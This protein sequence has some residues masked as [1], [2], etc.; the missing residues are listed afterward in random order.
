MCR[1]RWIV[2]FCGHNGLVLAVVAPGQGAQ[3]SGFLSAWLADPH[4]AEGLDHLGEAAGL[5]L[6]FF[7][8]QADDD[9]IRDTAIA[10]P[11]LVAAG[12][13]VADA[14]LPGESLSEVVGV[15]AGHS[16]GEV[17]AAVLADVLPADQAMVFIRER[18]QGMAAAAA[19]R[20]TSMAA[21][22]GGD[23]DEVVQAIT[24][25]DLTPANY[26]GKG[27]IVAAGTVEQ[28]DELPSRLPERT[29]V[30][31][32]SVAGAFHTHHMASG[33][34]RLRDVV[35]ALHPAD[36]AVAILSNRDGQQV[37]SGQEYVTRLVDQVVN[38]VRWDLCM[39]T[40]T[41][42]G[43]TGMLE[44]TPAGTLTGIAKRNMKVE[45]FNLNT[46]DQLGEA[47]Q[48]VAHHAGGQGA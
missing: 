8:T 21:V 5:D 20:P 27:Q 29:R 6:R 7:G 26:N 3:K 42:M 24:S 36:P 19:E 38:P 14:L 33:Q 4:F 13:L 45:L 15:T 28:L 30:I 46:P 44:L 32:L 16:V 31:P 47:R 43:V 34:A 40:M 39:Q 48:F 10:Q 22:I 1:L 41:E 9:T 2:G 17:T 12:I 37:A 35:P 18:A 23:P 25:C 11:L